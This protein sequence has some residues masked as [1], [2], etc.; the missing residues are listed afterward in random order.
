MK[1]VKT[2]RKTFI[3]RILRNLKKYFKGFR[4]KKYNGKTFTP[5]IQHEIQNII[6]KDRMIYLC[7]EKTATDLANNWQGTMILPQN[8][9]F[10]ENAIPVVMTANEKFAPYT[11]VMLQSLLKYSNPQRKY[12]FIFFEY[13]FSNIT[14][15]YLQ[16]QVSDFKHCSIE[17]INTKNILNNIPFSL[18]NAHFSI[19]IFSRL[20]IP[21]W[22][23][24]YPKV[25]YCDSD[26]IAKADISELYDLDIQNYCMGAVIDQGVNSAL[27]NKN[28]SGAIY[29]SSPAAFMLLENW[30][31]YI[32]SGLL[33]FNTNKFKENIPYDNLF[34][35]AIYY[36][37]RYKNIFG[38]QDILSLLV[39]D[40]YFVLPSEWNYC[41]ASFSFKDAGP[42]TKIVHF[43]SKI[44]PWKDYPEISNNI[45]ALAYRDFAKTIPLYSSKYQ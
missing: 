14:K 11:S 30:F 43:T 15:R 35:F 6:R 40:N 8:L 25:I 16:D 32:N 9:R 21:Y 37:N 1:L 3:W 7:N 5:D 18:S 10:I 13:D 23:D 36:T 24:K 44:K 34:K 31:R 2:I 26:M 4:I 17:F 22:L 33:V 20:F 42:N 38:D 41:W 12:H 28:Y 45:D 19:D 27:C 39:K 29:F